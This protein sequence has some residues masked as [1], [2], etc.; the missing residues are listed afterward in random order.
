MVDKG[1]V[2]LPIDKD[3]KVDISSFLK[4]KRHAVEI[5]S[6]DE[7]VKRLFNIEN[8]KKA[9][10]DAMV[11]AAEARNDSSI[12]QEVATKATERVYDKFFV[13]DKPPTGLRTRLMNLYLNRVNAVYKPAIVTVATIAIVTGSVLTVNYTMHNAH[14]AKLAK[15]EITVERTI[16]DLFQS[17]MNLKN[18]MKEISTYVSEKTPVDSS[19]LDNIITLAEGQLRSTDLFFAQ[20]KP[21]EE[22]VTRENYIEAGKTAD[23]IKGILAQVG[24]QLSKGKDMIAVNDGLIVVKQSLDSLIGEVRSAKPVDV[25]MDKANTAYQSGISTV[26][27]RQLKEAQG[28]RQELEKI[29]TN[30][31]QFAPMPAELDKAYQAI[32]NIVQHEPTKQWAEKMYL[33]GNTYVKNVDIPNLEQI[34]QDLSDKAAILAQEYEIFIVKNPNRDI[35]T[36]WDIEWYET[37]RGR[38][39]VTRVDFFARAQATKNGNII[40][41]TFYDVAKDKTVTAETFGVRISGDELGWVSDERMMEEFREFVGSGEYQKTPLL[42][43]V[44]GYPNEKVIYTSLITNEVLPFSDKTSMVPND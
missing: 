38:E 18:Q 15:Q 14:E 30:V 4:A 20:Y 8:E 12:T 13:F 11:E 16:D 9:F 39:K 22:Q 29:K 40:P 36:V 24:Q 44:R 3:G 43:K 31:H 23:T 35:R 19:D 26:E 17:M 10:A 34:T 25:L 7:E 28:Y 6:D 1:I 37:E 21:T 42:V 41:L 27:H 5:A 32:M 33:E 2:K